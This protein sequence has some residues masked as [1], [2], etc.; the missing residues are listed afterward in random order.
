MRRHEQLPERISLHC[1]VRVGKPLI[2]GMH[3]IVASEIFMEV[4]TC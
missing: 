2:N 3:L 1:E 4:R